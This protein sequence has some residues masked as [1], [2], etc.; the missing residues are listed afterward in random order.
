M[1]GRDFVL[2]LRDH[3]G[4]TR[5]GELEGT[6]NDTTHAVSPEIQL[7]GQDEWTLQYMDVT[8]VQ[9]IMEAFGD[10]AASSGIV[11]VSEVNAFTARV[12]PHNWR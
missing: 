3:F 11:T 9:A 1:E 8:R 10:A 4:E 2:A 12:P 6:T 5:A 7:S